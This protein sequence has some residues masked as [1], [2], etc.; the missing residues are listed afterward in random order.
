MALEL[1][2]RRHSWEQSATVL[3][4]STFPSSPSSPRR[5]TYSHCTLWARCLLKLVPLP[6]WSLLRLQCP[7]WNIAHT[8]YSLRFLDR[9]PLRILENSRALRPTRQGPQESREAPT[10]VWIEKCGELVERECVKIELFLSLFRTFPKEPSGWARS[11]IA[12]WWWR[13]C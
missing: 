12:G 9:Y 3:L 6:L 1:L 11:E 5:I 13:F 10:V 7:L 2:R 4:I 8:I